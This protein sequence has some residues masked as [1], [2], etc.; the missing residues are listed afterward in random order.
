M[1]INWPGLCIKY[2]IA[3]GNDNFEEMHNL[4][5]QIIYAWSTSPGNP[6]ISLEQAFNIMIER[7][8]A[9]TGDF[10]FVR[11]DG[12]DFS[13]TTVIG[14]TDCYDC[15]RNV[16]TRVAE[17]V[18]CP[19]GWLSRPVVNGLSEN[20]CNDRLAIENRRTPAVSRK[21]PL[22]QEKIEG[23]PKRRMGRRAMQRKLRRQ[24]RRTR[25][26]NR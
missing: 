8:P 24:K 11:P 9:T 5:T 21:R 1:S 16:M 22:S 13:D 25:R 10:V 6:V 15:R 17:G 2:K 4:L 20:P 12:Y 3:Q 7:C 19:D 14:Q 26:R 18:K 23:R